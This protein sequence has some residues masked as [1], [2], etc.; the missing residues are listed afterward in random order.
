[1]G[2]GWGTGWEVSLYTIGL[3]IRIVIENNDNYDE[4]LD[5]KK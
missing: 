5:G 2:R 1:M 4:I 3:L